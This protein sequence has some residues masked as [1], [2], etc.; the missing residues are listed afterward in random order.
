LL[1]RPPEEST[2][3][4]LV[5][6]VMRRAD[7]QPDAVNQPSTEVGQKAAR[8][9][10]C[11]GMAIRMKNRR[12]GAEKP[13]VVQRHRHGNV[14]RAVRDAGEHGGERESYPV[15]EMDEVW[16]LATDQIAHC[17]SDLWVIEIDRTET[18]LGQQ[19]M[20][21]AGQVSNIQGCDAVDHDA[22]GCD[23][24]SRRQVEAR[25]ARDNH[26]LVFGGQRPGEPADIDL[27]TA[28]DERRVEIADE[29]DFHAA[30]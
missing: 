21:E 1:G 26:D 22:F 30:F 27:R 17:G 2:A 12:I 19:V 7:D 25:L 24:A 6:Y 10:R 13:I 11:A 20:G 14:W 4:V 18:G 5:E 15:M 8:K 23:L 29:A 9:I 3:K 28:L 16:P